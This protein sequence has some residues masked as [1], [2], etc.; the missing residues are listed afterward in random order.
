MHFKRYLKGL[1]LSQGLAGTGC[2]ILSATAAEVALPDLHMPHAF[3]PRRCCARC[4]DF[5]YQGETFCLLLPGGTK[6]AVEGTSALLLL[7]L[8]T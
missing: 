2:C 7:L 4:G 1:A 5:A 6:V 3:V 8:Q